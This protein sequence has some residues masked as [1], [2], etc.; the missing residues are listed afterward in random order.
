MMMSRISTDWTVMPQAFVCVENLPDLLPQPV[1]VG[2]HVAE[3]VPADG[4]A[5][6][7]L[8]GQTDRGVEVFHLEHRLFSVPDHPKG[9][10][11]DVDRHRVLGERGLGLEIGDPNPLVDVVGDLVHRELPFSALSTL[12]EVLKNVVESETVGRSPR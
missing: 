7:G 5:E 10:G 4:V 3:L 12:L 6:T 11:V 1:A 2:E 8:R 9:D